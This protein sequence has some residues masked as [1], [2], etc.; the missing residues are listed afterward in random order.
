MRK[1]SKVI[2]TSPQGVINEFIQEME[3][4]KKS[5]E[6]VWIRPIGNKSEGTKTRIDYVRKI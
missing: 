2:Y 1:G 4:T 3:V 6:W 5:G